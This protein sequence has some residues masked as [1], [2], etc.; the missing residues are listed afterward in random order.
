MAQIRALLQ[1]TLVFYVVEIGVIGI[2]IFGGIRYVMHDKPNSEAMGVLVC[3]WCVLFCVILIKNVIPFSL[4]YLGHDVC[5]IQGIYENNVGS[6]STSGSSGLGFYAVTITNDDQ[7]KLDLTTIPLAQDI[8]P[9]GVYPVKAYYTQRSRM[10][11]YIEILEDGIQTVFDIAK[12]LCLG[13][14]GF[15]FYLQHLIDGNA[16]WDLY[17]KLNFGRSSQNHSVE[18]GSVWYT[19]GEVSRC[20][21]QRPI[22]QSLFQNN[23]LDLL[24]LFLLIVIGIVLRF[25]YPS[26]MKN[27]KS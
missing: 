9:V 4:D 5:E 24:L 14:A 17:T 6:D 23:A 2:L 19:N 7:E 13:T 18:V 15:V 8:F 27:M 21:V 3:I 10:L 26:K 22:W 1:Q 20:V 11:V 25:P 16:I 12:L